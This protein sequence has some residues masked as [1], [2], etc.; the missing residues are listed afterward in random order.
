[1]SY[2]D[3]SPKSPRFGDAGMFW[4]AGR[5]KDQLLADNEH[6]FLKSSKRK[7]SALHVVHYVAPSGKSG[8]M[9]ALDRY[10]NGPV[11]VASMRSS[12]TDP[13]ALFVGIKA[14]YNQVNHG[15]LDLGS[16]ELEALGEHWFYDL[17]G[18]DYAVKDYFDMESRRW[19]YYRAASASHNVPLIDGKNQNI[20]AVSKFKRIALNTPEPWVTV[21]LSEAYQ[22]DCTSME[23]GIKMMDARRAVLVQDEYTLKEARTLSWGVMTD[24]T[25]TLNGREAELTLKGKK[26]R[27]TILTPGAEFKEVSARQEAA[28]KSNDGYRRLYYEVKA[29]PGRHTLA[30]LIRPEGV[31]LA[32]P[33]AIQKPLA[34]W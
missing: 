34:Q 14:G 3:S 7:V 32:S 9:Q 6:E 13:K 25:I 26:L 21:D 23:R 2:A 5:F 12:W 31:E 8:Q 11:A 30:V 24:A 27:L 29:S 22:E 28:Q 15:H 17:G 4:M 10:F 16:I 20:H 1:M 33:E 19:T 18:E